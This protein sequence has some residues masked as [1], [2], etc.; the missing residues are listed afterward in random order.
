MKGLLELIDGE[1]LVA[2]RVGLRDQPGC[3]VMLAVHQA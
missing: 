3:G 1:Q 2:W